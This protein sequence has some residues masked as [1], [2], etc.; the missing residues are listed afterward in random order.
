MFTLQVILKLLF[1]KLLIVDILT[2]LLN[3]LNKLSMDKLTSVAVYNVS[4]P[5]TEIWHT[6]LIYKLLFPRSTNL[7]VLETILPAKTPVCMLVG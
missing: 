3:L 1:G 5:E 2:L 6:V 7:W 4:S